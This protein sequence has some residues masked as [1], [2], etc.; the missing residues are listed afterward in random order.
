M[1]RVHP[2]LQ[3]ELSLF[4]FIFY[5]L[6]PCGIY[7][8]SLLQRKLTLLVYLSLAARVPDQFYFDL[9]DPFSL[10]ELVISPS[11]VTFNP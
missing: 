2:V 6:F 8:L 4:W 7:L 9:Y 10:V 1:A 11:C 3:Y 5:K